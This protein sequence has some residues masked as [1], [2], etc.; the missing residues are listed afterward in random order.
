[1]ELLRAWATDPDDPRTIILVTHATENVTTC[2]YVVFMA[3]GGHVA[4]FG[5]PS[6]ALRYFGVDRFAEIYRQ[7][8]DYQ[9]GSDDD[10][11]VARR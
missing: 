7:V 11:D 8:S 1:M 9:V 10:R 4:Y 3:P 6:A 5:P 2:Q